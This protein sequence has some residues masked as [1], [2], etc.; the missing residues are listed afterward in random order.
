MFAKSQKKQHPLQV[1]L[2]LEKQNLTSQ[3]EGFSFN[4]FL[5][6]VTVVNCNLIKNEKKIIT[7]IRH[8]VSVF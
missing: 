5:G 6:Y 8:T 4:P 7:N 2:Y 3:V 1:W